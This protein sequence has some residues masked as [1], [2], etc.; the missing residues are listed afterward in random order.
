MEEKEKKI[1][2]IKKQEKDKKGKNEE[3]IQNNNIINVDEE[4]ENENN[5]KI[6]TKNPKGNNKA[7]FFF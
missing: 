6:E 1:G 3:I 7:D 4:I 2:K 5:S